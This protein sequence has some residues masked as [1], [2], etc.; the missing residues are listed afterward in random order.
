MDEPMNLPPRQLSRSETHDLGMIIRDRGKVLKAHAEAQA[1]A[2]MA[3]FESKMAA[4]YTYDQ[5]PVWKKA[6]AKAQDV[7]NQAQDEIM[8]RCEEL[9]IPRVFAPSVGLAWNG[10]GENALAMRRLELRRVAKSA[11]DAMVKAAITNVEK[12]SLNLRTQV[13]AMGLLSADARLFLESLAPIEES[14]RSLDFAEIER[15]LDAEQQLR[16]ADHRRLYGGEMADAHPPRDTRALSEGLAGDQPT[17]PLRA[18]GR[19]MRVDQRRDSLRRRA[20]RKSPD[21][22][23]TRCAHDDAP[24]PR[25]DE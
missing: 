22:R 1:A 5:D 19:S 12:Q 13:V 20:W 17:H 3:D 7:V 16:V 21:H 15:K 2:C 25:S 11:I 23:R 6:A 4:E 8:K 10:R 18:R 14:M 9:G 24:R